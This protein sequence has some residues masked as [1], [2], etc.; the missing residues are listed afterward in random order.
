MSVQTHIAGNKLNIRD[1]WMH[2]YWLQGWA[3]QRKV[4]ENR[5]YQIKYT[6]LSFWWNEAEHPND[7]IH[8]LSLCS[9]PS[10]RH[11]QSNL[12]IQ[13]CTVSTH[14]RTQTLVGTKSA[15]TIFADGL[16]HPSFKA[17]CLAL[18][19]FSPWSLVSQRRCFKTRLRIKS[20]NSVFP[21]TFWYTFGEKQKKKDLLHSTRCSAENMAWGIFSRHLVGAALVGRMW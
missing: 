11:T 5:S 19:S 6:K 15:Q 2:A 4:K 13:S 12:I 3:N 8:C 14:T 18:C 1:E 20:I 16:F 10:S 7:P 17:S 9:A 21:L